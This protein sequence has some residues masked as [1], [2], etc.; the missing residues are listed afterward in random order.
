M[1]FGTVSMFHGLPQT[2]PA[3]PADPR[4]PIL[5]RSLEVAESAAQLSSAVPP[6]LLA[7][8]AAELAEAG[9]RA[10]QAEERLNAL[11]RGD[12]TVAAGLEAAS[13]SLASALRQLGTALEAEQRLRQEAEGQMAA[14]GASHDAL[15]MMLS[16]AIEDVR[17][18]ISRAMNAAPAIRGRPT[19]PRGLQGNNELLG[20]AHRATLAR[21]NAA[22]QALVTAQN[23]AL[24]ELAARLTALGDAPRYQPL[25]EAAA[26]LKAAHEALAMPT[27]PRARA[28]ASGQEVT[29]TAARLNDAVARFQTVLGSVLAAAAQEAKGARTQPPQ[30]LPTQALPI[31]LGALAFGLAALTAFLTLRRVQLGAEQ[32]AD[33]AL[34]ATLRIDLGS[35]EAARDEAQAALSQLRAEHAAL[36]AETVQIL[37]TDIAPVLQGVAQAASNNSAMLITLTKAQMTAQQATSGIGA[38]AE[39][40]RDETGKVAAAAEELTETVAAVSEQIRNS[41]SIAAQAVGDAGRTDTIVRGLSGAAEKIGDVVKLIT[42]IAGQTNLL[43]LNATIEAARAGDAGKGFAVV[44]SEV[45]ALAAQT[46]R[47]TEEISR[48]VQEIRST[49]A[50]AVTAIQGIA[51]VVQR[52]DSIAAEAANAIEQQGVATREIAQGITAAAEGTSAVVG[53]IAKVQGGMEAAGAPVA[54]LDDQSH[55]MARQSAALQQGIVSLAARLRAA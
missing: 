49:S 44:A 35:A 26:A 27:G 21:D 40:A 11:L 13:T 30:R 34:L 29:A 52:I 12:A 41:A 33:N 25:H 47:A 5:A 39:R 22:Y 54:A 48:Q 50:E 32:R 31:I 53:A 37:E 1:G 43:A 10:R 18:D 28:A 51:E 15:R 4:L 16:R 14:L 7:R 20:I 19:R 55:A 45:K 23:A 42:A 2:L 8:S 24:M 6:M 46:A 9:R 38:S 36:R 3:P 17:Q